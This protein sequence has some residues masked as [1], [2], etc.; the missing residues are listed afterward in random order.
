M[1]DTD[2]DWIAMDGPLLSERLPAFF[3]LDVR[4]DHAWRRPWGTLNLYLDVQNVTNRRNAEG[5]TYNTDYS[6][7]SYTRG[8]PIFPSIGVEYI[9]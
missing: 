9:P 7:R 1:Q 6:V 4:L 8:L 3:Q 2:G 5:V